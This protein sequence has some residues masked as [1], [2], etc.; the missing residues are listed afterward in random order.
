MIEELVRPAVVAHGIQ[1]EHL[2]DTA[3]LLH[4][5]LVASAVS[6]AMWGALIWVLTKVG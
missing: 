2:E 4:G 5:L 6:V 1:D 3:A